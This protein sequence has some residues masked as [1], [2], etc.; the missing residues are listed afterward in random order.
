MT[1]VESTELRAN[2]LGP[3]VLDA[4][5]NQIGVNLLDLLP[6][7][8][9]ACDTEGRILLFNRRAAELWGREPALN[10]SADLFCGAHRL[11]RLDGGPLPHDE[12]PMADVLKTGVPVRNQ[13]VV[14]ERE[15]GQRAVA[16]VNI[17]PLLDQGGRILGAV[18]CFQDITAR[19]RAEQEQLRARD[20]VEALTKKLASERDQSKALLEALPAAIYTTD[21]VGRVTYYNEAAAQ[22]WG[23][24]PEIGKAEFCGSWKLYRLDGTPMA[25]REC[26]MARALREKRP[27]RGERAVAERPDGTRIQFIP[28]PTPL[29][30]DDGNLTG[31]VNMLVDASEQQRLEEVRQRLAAVVE[32]SSDAIISKNLDGIIA[33]WNKGA[34]RIFGYKAE[35]V[36]GKSILVLIPPENHEEETE[37][38][39]KLRRGERI[40]HY[41]T[42]RRR[43][44][45]T[46]INISL[47]ISPLYDNCGRVIG[48]SKIARDI[49]EQKK[50]QAR[51]ELLSNEL[52][53]RT[54][55]LFTVVRSV[56]TRS[57]DRKRNVSAAKEAV[58]Q[59]LHSLAQTHEMLI[60]NE[61][62]GANLRDVVRAELNP[63]ADRVEIDGPP[64]DLH[65]RAAQ[66]FALAIHELATNASKYGALSNEFGKVFVSWSLSEQDDQTRFDFEWRERGG[67]PV[68]KPRKNG[69]GSS[70]VL[71][72]MA[73]HADSPPQIEFAAEGL[74]Y[75]LS[76]PLEL[77]AMSDPPTSIPLR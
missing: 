54:R 36:I 23:C 65:A 74:R 16:L 11:Y 42:M 12:C 4:A 33:S 18:N 76:G 25:H 72:I 37:I 64:L 61:W 48:A 15:D 49:T 44:D 53:H 55:N 1:S 8:I 46:L 39:S 68:R 14:V 69:F 75:A 57:F 7:A 51:Q 24:R 3:L 31:A 2:D 17:D 43:K 70:V 71:R 21:E 32:S 19:K 73:M 52:Q 60:V 22:L 40:E 66:D 67:P 47:S 38:L 50:A 35:E 41:E 10:D 13:E 58:L 59:R 20:K 77:V 26:P 5:R 30:D 9:Y 28:F 6:A 45:G 29:F 63:Y 34:E 62:C 56:V 27:I